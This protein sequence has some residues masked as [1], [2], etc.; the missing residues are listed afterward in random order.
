MNR[1]ALNFAL[2]NG[3]SPTPSSD[4][5]FNPNDPKTKEDIMRISIQYLIRKDKTRASSNRFHLHGDIT[6][7]GEP[8]RRCYTDKEPD[9]K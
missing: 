8:P 6:R 5:L 7:C 2:V 1:E 3:M 4:T 9:L